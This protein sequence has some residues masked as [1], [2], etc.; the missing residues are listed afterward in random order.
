M[1]AL[2]SQVVLEP[3]AAARSIQR[4]SIGLPCSWLLL[5]AL[6]APFGVASDEELGRGL[7]G[8]SLASLGVGSFALAMHQGLPGHLCF[9]ANG[10]ATIAG[11]YAM[12]LA[13]GESYSVVV[14]RA[15]GSWKGAVCCT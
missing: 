9:L 1:R 3:A 10:A 6:A 8:L 11:A 4:L 15:S 2:S 14:K 13:R 5:A 12:A 7:R